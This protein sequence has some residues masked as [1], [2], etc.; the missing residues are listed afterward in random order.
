M[1][2]YFFAAI[3]LCTAGLSAPDTLRQSM[4][5]DETEPAYKVFYENGF[6]PE[7]IELLR[8]KIEER[9]DT[10]NLDYLAYLA[11]CYAA[12]GRQDSAIDVFNKILDCDS[13]FYLDTVTTSP[14]IL[15][16]LTDA[17]DQWRA[18]KSSPDHSSSPAVLLEP[19]P[20]KGAT[21]LG[22]S[23]DTA[24]APVPSLGPELKPIG[25]RGYVY[26]CVPG[27]AG[28]FHSQHPIRGSVL[29]ALQAI[30][31][32]GGYWAYQ[33]RGDYYDAQ[34]G[35]GDWNRYE[36]EKYSGFSMAGFGVF[37]SA[38]VVSVADGLI[39]IGKSRHQ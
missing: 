20:S 35:W 37:I 29:L 3:S 11:F 5:T 26:A 22:V 25:W 21:P 4:D 28:Q 34:H 19:L 18:R 32:A 10:V 31:F 33:K 36:Y 39:T 1:I 9:P 30:G 16:V 14:K 8:A 23:A 12:S 2:K 15:R 24:P 6:Y 7:A 17:Q 38:Y 13:A 27:G